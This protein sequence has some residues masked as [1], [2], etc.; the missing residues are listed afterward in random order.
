MIGQ[1]LGTACPL[2][3]ISSASARWFEALSGGS[4]SRGLYMIVQLEGLWGRIGHRVFSDV[5]V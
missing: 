1:A 2:F 5:P 3:C 4:M